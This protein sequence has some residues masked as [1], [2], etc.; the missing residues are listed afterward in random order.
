[1]KISSL[2]PCQANLT[3][4]T[5]LSESDLIGFPVSE[6]LASPSRVGRVFPLGRGPKFNMLS[7][8]EGSFRKEILDCWTE[9]LHDFSRFLFRGDATIGLLG[10]DAIFA[11]KP[12]ITDVYSTDGERGHCDNRLNIERFFPEKLA[13]FA[14]EV[15]GLFAIVLRRGNSW[16]KLFI[17]LRFGFCW[18]LILSIFDR[19]SFVSNAYPSLFDRTVSI[20]K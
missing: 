15:D 8:S 7:N 16:V 14:F 4:N 10:S 20:S 3:S 12:S 2:D 1:M 19:E 5:F 9:W 6:A 18:V 17:L 13:F 11:L